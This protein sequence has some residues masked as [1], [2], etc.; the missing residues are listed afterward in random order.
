M[1]EHLNEFKFSKEKC[2]VISQTGGKLLV[3]FVEAMS[4]PYGTSFRGVAPRIH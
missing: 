3:A 1:N 4:G 2:S